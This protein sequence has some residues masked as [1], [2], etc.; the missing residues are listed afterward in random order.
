MVVCGVA[1][2]LASDQSQGEKARPP[3]PG[4]ILPSWSRSVKLQALQLPVLA[5]ADQLRCSTFLKPI[6]AVLARWGTGCS[7]KEQ[8]MNQAIIDE[9]QSANHMN[10]AGIKLSVPELF[11]D[12]D[13]QD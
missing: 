5:T 6:W 8:A 11:R 7:T 1:H 2:L 3:W 12:S 9:I 4:G 10:F 13:F